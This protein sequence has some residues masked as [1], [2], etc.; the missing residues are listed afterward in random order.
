MGDFLGLVRI[1]QDGII[2]IAFGGDGKILS[3]PP[4]GSAGYNAGAMQSDG[5]FLIAGTMETTCWFYVIWQAE[6]L[7]KTFNGNG[8]QV[9]SMED[10]MCQ[11]NAIA[12]QPDGKII[13]AGY[14]YRSGNESV[15]N[16]TS[17]CGWQF[18][19]SFDMDGKK[20]FGIGS[21]GA[22][23]CRAVAVQPDGKILL[24]GSSLDA[25]GVRHFL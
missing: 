7:D 19:N 22:E 9:I 8:Q 21:F 18:D 11:G 3:L 6:P 16:C 25:N 1:K 23:E 2:D 4:A 20:A 13:V 17:E 12:L 10:V 5:K 14:S 15:F 24:A